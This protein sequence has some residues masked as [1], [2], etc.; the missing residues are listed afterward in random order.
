VQLSKKLENLVD[1]LLNKD[2]VNEMTDEELHRSSFFLL[3]G[4]SFGRIALF[5]R[6]SVGKITLSAE[7][8]PAV[9]RYAQHLEK[10]RRT[11]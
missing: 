6:K 11:W 7:V 8:L 4:G 3:D 1:S 5:G 10:G 9:N 2:V